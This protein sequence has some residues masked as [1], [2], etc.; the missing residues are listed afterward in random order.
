MP[1]SSH[2]SC[3][4]SFCRTGTFSRR[5]AMR[6]SRTRSV[7]ATGQRSG[8]LVIVGGGPAGLAAAVYAASKACDDRVEREAIGARSTSS[9]IRN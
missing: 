8:D 7:Q 1:V 4:L 6:T 2:P 9:L 5:R 3:R